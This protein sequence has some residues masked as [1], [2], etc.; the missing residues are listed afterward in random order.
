MSVMQ[1]EPVFLCRRCNRPLVV[2]HLSTTSADPDGR[3]LHEF[4]ANLHKIAFCDLC[5]KQRNWYAA[6]DRIEDWEAGRP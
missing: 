4:M 1:T 5:R 3:L 6:N 2:K